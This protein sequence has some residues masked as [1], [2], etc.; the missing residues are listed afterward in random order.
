MSYLPKVEVGVKRVYSPAFDESA[1][2]SAQA[3]RKWYALDGIRRT[4]GAICNLQLD[5]HALSL[6]NWFGSQ[7][8]QG[9]LS[10]AYIMVKCNIMKIHTRPT[11]TSGCSADAKAVLYALLVNDPA[12]VH[13][14]TQFTLPFL[15][16]GVNERLYK[17]PYEYQHL[18][19]QIRLALQMDLAL[20]GERCEQALAVEPKRNK[21]YRLDYQFFKGYALNDRGL[22]QTA[23]DQLLQTK[24]LRHRHGDW[25][26]ESYFFA[27][28]AMLYFKIAQRAGFRLEVDH[29]WMPKEWLAP[30]HLDKIPTSFDFIDEFDLFTPFFD[31]ENSS[32]CKNASVLTPRKLGEPMLMF[33]EVEA[34]FAGLKYQGGL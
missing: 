18:L 14:H 3:Y 12:L 8:M 7:D 5:Y 2:E 16:G 19:L 28:W 30:L 4:Y 33:R 10:A 17:K 6:A 25:H 29:P 23:L 9:F 34:A 32:W 31:N 22:M 1:N 24:V 20:L 21:T 15:G 11:S 27:G 26:R 13:W